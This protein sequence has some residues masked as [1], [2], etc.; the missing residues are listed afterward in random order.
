MGKVEQKNEFFV[1]NFKDASVGIIGQGMLGLAAW[2]NYFANKSDLFD[3]RKT[4]RVIVAPSLVDIPDLKAAVNASNGLPIHIAAQDVS[5]FKAGGKA[6]TGQVKAETL[7]MRGIEYVIIA[8]S[9]TRKDLKLDD[10]D[11]KAKIKRAEES[12]MTPIVCVENVNDAK[13]FIEDQDFAGLIAFEPP[14]AIGTGDPSDPKETRKVCRQIRKLFPLA[15]ILY[16][17]SVKPSNVRDYLK[18][19]EINGVLVGAKTV[20]AQFF[21]DIIQATSYKKPAVH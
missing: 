14:A 7:A 3:P 10:S 12:G 5:P 11:V 17:G 2:V 16:G 20:N 18:I 4:R 21:A 1:A 6:H 19:P 13:R 8:H 9:E 15:S